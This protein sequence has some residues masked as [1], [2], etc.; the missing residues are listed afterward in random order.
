M[1]QDLM[2]PALNCTVDPNDRS[3]PICLDPVLLRNVGI[4][5]CGHP[6]HMKC[7]KAYKNQ[8]IARNRVVTCPICQFDTQGYCYQVRL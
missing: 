5:A 4:P 3:C 7:C 8:M 2:S 6:M 1:L